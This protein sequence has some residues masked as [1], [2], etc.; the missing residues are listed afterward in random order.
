MFTGIVETVGKVVNLN[1][2]GNNLHLTINSTFASELKIDQSISHNGVCLTVVGV[3]KEKNTYSVV[4]IDETLRKSNIG[5]LKIGD[6]LNLER[7][8]K[9]GDRLD[10][11]IVQ[12]HVDATVLC[13]EIKEVGGSHKFQFKLNQN[14]DSQIVKK[15]SVCVNGVSL[16]VV[17]ISEDAFSVAIIPYTFNNTNFSFMQV[18]SLANIEFDIVGKYVLSQVSK[19]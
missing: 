7:S 17:D 2:E 11:H 13:V 8:L 15:G 14:I 6:S 16:T 1:E 12:G 4:A 19:A 5:L 10:G 18:G 3:D 9:L